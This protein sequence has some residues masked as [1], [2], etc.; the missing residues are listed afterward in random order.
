[1]TKVDAIE[2]VLEDNGGSASLQVIYNNIEKYYP[3][4]KASKNWAAGLRGVLY[5]E[6]SFGNRFKK[7]GLSIYALSDYHVERIN[8]FTKV[9]RHSLMEGICIELGNSQNYDTFT[10]DPSAIYRDNTFLGHIASIS[11]IPKFSYSE[12]LHQAKLIDVLWFNKSKLSFPQYAFEIVDSIGTL[13]GALNRCIQLHNFRTIFFI[14]APE[15]HR[16]KYNQTMELEIYRQSND[17]FEFLPYDK[18]INT[19]D[20]LVNDND[21]LNWLR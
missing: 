11:D 9:R 20:R 10:A 6:L 8:K 7:I 13:N 16:T 17:L 5:R 14:V 19:Y 21:N 4:A 18:L 2:K 15:E 1:M 12:I 3:A